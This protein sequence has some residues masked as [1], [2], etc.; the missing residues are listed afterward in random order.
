MSLRPADVLRKFRPQTVP[1]TPKIGGDTITLDNEGNPI[2]ARSIGQTWDGYT[3]E[4]SP[5]NNSRAPITASVMK[6]IVGQGGAQIR[7]EGGNNQDRVTERHAD[8]NNLT[9]RQIQN[10]RKNESETNNPGF[11]NN[12]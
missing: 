9:A 3:E 8:I 12:R 2:L 1:T 10:G 11:G 6:G 7:H 4:V 5:A